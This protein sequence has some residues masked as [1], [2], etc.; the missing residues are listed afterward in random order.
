LKRR[1][2]DKEERE[3]NIEEERGEKRILK[4]RGERR[5]IEE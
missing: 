3:E 5:R 4:R 2:E 1:G